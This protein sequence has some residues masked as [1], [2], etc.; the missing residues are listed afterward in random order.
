MQPGCMFYLLHIISRLGFFLGGSRG[1]KCNICC[2]TTLQKHPAT[3][4]GKL[5]KPCR[6]QQKP[7]KTGGKAEK[8]LQH[9][10]ETCRKLAKHCKSM[11]KAGKTRNAPHA[12]CETRPTLSGKPVHWAPRGP[13]TGRKSPKICDFHTILGDSRPISDPQKTKWKGVFC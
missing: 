11:Q 10:A 3:P 8:T 6:T 9:T 12:Q 5:R 2:V 1:F 13:E 4:V 7:C